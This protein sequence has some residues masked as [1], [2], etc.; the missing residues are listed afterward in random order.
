MTDKLYND[1]VML[2]ECTATVLA[3][4]EKDD[5]FLVELDR[6]VI[7]PEGGGQLSDRGKINDVNVLHAIEKEGRIF[8]E[9]DQP[10][11]VGAQVTVTLDWAVRLDK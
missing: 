5:K 11:E 1:N 9:C 6:T 4:E 2:K 10:L 7:F 8:H 3:C